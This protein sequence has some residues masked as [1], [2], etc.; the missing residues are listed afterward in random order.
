[1][2]NR[3][4]FVTLFFEMKQSKATRIKNHPSSNFQR[5]KSLFLLDSVKE[6]MISCCKTAHIYY[7][8][9]INYNFL[10]I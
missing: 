1:M 4:Y 5:E 10:S 2:Q 6:M 7:S 3:Y 8:N 9:S